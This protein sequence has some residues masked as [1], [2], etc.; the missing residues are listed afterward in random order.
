MHLIEQLCQILL[1]NLN[2]FKEINLLL[3]QMIVIKLRKSIITI[4]IL[5]N[6]KMRLKKKNQRGTILN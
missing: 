6:Y 3:C 4:K 5:S 1:K 2:K